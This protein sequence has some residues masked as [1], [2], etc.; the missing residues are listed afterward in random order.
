MLTEQLSARLGLSD[1][2]SG[3]VSMLRWPVVFAFLV[4]AT[5]I[6]F[7]YAPNV[8]VAW[9]WTFA[10]AVTFALGWLVATYALAWY[11]GNYGAYGTTYGSLG[12]IIVLMLWFYVTGLLLVGSAE[13]IATFATVLEPEA[14]QRR[15]DEL[16]AARRSA[17]VQEAKARAGA[18]ANRVSD[19]L[20]GGDDA[21][22][23]RR[24]GP[25]DRRR[26]LDG[27]P[28]EA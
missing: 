27:P 10:G 5:S 6:L 2:G 20:P 7:R 22:G 1:T 26:G 16:Q 25:P 13:L 21:E 17:L 19:A 8:R 15:R 11:I 9:R 14:L 18:V 23:E 24:T 3:L 12:A 4:V 28:V